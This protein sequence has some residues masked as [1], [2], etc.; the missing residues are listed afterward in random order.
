MVCGDRP[1]AH[2]RQVEPALVATMQ[3][4]FPT[5]GSGHF[6]LRSFASASK[7]SADHYNV[8]GIRRTANQKDVKDAFY[9]LSKIYHPDV[10]KN[11]VALQKFQD[12]TAAYETL[13]TPES[14]DAYDAATQPVRNQRLTSTILRRDV[15]NADDYTLSYK[16][17][18]KTHEKI[19]IRTHPE[20][21]ATAS[22]RPSGSDH[23]GAGTFDSNVMDE[24]YETFRGS[25][26]ANPIE[27]ERRQASGSSIVL[28]ALLC[29]CAIVVLT[30]KQEAYVQKGHRIHLSNKKDC[31]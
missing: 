8:L 4:S 21:T 11:E 15:S 10:N 20:S 2:T 14:R 13:G 16:M 29:L 31:D 19:R 9:R 17:R 3:R 27:D 25:G 28:L 22:K 5:R 30:Q 26:R 1:D 24:L 7:S 18:K 6:V 23:Y 12:I